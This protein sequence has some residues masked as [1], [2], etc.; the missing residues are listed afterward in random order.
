MISLKKIL[1]STL[2]ILALFAAVAAHAEARR[3]VLLA[4]LAPTPGD[5]DYGP[6]AP[7]E[8]YFGYA[9][10][11]QGDTA[12]IGMPGVPTGPGGWPEVGRVAV[13]THS[14]TQW[15]RPQTLYAENAAP[16]EWFGRL[17]AMQGDTAVIGSNTRIYVFHR[18]PDG[19]WRP[20]QQITPPST[21]GITRYPLAL[22]MY[23]DTAVV[24]AEAGT[25]RLVY[26]YQL[27]ADG[28][29]KWAARIKSPTADPSEEFA[30]SLDTD[31]GWLVVGAPS[32]Q[33]SPQSSGAAYVFHRV[34]GKWRFSQKII[35][36]NGAAGDRFGASVAMDNYTIVVGA[37]LHNRQINEDSLTGAGGAAYVYIAHG[38]PFVESALLR[39]TASENPGYGRLGEQVAITSDRIVV[40]AARLEADYPHNPQRFLFTYVRYSALNEV[41]GVA[42][43]FYEGGGFSIDQHNLLVGDP[44]ADATSG[45]RIGIAKIFDLVHRLP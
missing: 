14:G 3:H 10:A 13:F 1:L 25:E 35:P 9:V 31:R 44:D 38:G 45:P 32:K 4:T 22:A 30:S 24:S 29:F 36:N 43:G 8:A 5:Y 27:Q 23:S 18:G 37:P 20:A 21:D 19:I 41:L 15:L 42:K 17:V 40:S 11:I 16:G 6:G 34:D 39:P 26:V 2:S 7:P 33:I 28:R 12:L